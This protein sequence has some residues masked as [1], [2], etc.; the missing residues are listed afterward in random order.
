[1]KLG[2]LCR[3]TELPDG[4]T[5]DCLLCGA[6]CFSDL[7]QYVAVLGSDYER[8][9]EL[10]EEVTTWHGIRC[11]MRMHEG[12]CA[13]LVV[14]PHSGRFV[15]SV[16]ELRPETCRT[17]ARASAECA[18]ERHHKHQRTRRALRVV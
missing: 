8:L 6:C 17:L 18:G 12:H 14:E 11:F 5:P 1:M 16:Y 7:P 2:L 4:D 3:V 10:A 15:C 9:G 13:A